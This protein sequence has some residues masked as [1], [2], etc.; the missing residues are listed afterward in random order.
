MCEAQLP[1]PVSWLLCIML[2]LTSPLLPAS[3]HTPQV[4]KGAPPP[5]QYPGVPGGVPPGAPYNP[6]NKHLA[7]AYQQ[8]QQQQQQQQHL[9]RSNSAV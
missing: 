2:G 9:I 4:G 1:A 6:A 5:T 7:G 8:Q 3:A